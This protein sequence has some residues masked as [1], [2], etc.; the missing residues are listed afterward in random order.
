MNIRGQRRQSQ[1]GQSVVE[2]SMIV[3]VV[4]LMLLGMLE[5][6]FV[7]DHSATIGNATREGARMGSAL[8]NGGGTLGCLTT[9]AQ[10]PNRDDVDGRIVAAVQRILAAPGSRVVLA[11]VDE[12]RIYNATSTGTEITGQVNVWVYSA[13]GTMT[14]DGLV[15][16]APSGSQPWTPCS[17]SF[18]WTTCATPPAGL[19]QCPPDSI[20]VGIKYTYRYV[21]PLAGIMR[22]FGGTGGAT[23]PVS[24]RAVMAMNPSN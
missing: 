21:T 3:P 1:R 17:R 6:G 19:V 4:L 10:S 12:I 22:F 15:N 9:P 23:L 18:V 7:F 14:A 20:G 13:G 2:F 16:F 8:V 5:F 11:D 24:E